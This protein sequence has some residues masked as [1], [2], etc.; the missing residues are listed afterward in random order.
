MRNIRK[1]NGLLKTNSKMRVCKVVK[2]V[3]CRMIRSGNCTMVRVMLSNSFQEAF[4]G[5]VINTFLGI[6][7]ES[8]PANV[9]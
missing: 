8:R 2:G 4:S 5:R 7:R 1:K 6:L 3:T 9:S